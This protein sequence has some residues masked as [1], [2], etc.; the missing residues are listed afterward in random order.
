EQPID[1]SHQMHAGELEISC[2]YCHTSVEKS[3][4][5]EIPATST[6]MN[7]HEYV[8]APWDSV[9]LEEQLASEQNRDP[10][11]VVSPEIQKLYQSA[12]FDP[13]SMEYIEN[14][15]PYSI[16]WNKVHHLP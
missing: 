8:S 13:Q 9:K 2:K 16:R 10:E 4:T 15:N 11:L 12:G 3:Q 5:A 1:F 7:C 6:C 14:E